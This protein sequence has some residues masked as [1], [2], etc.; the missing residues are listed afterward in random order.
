M[1]SILI[2]IHNGIEFIDDSVTSV[3]NQSCSY[4][5]ILIGVNGHPENSEI[6]KIAKKYEKKH[7]KIRVF[8]FY[9]LRGKVNTLNELIQYC[10]YDH[11]AVLDV[12]DVWH[13]Y[14]LDIQL[15]YIKDYDIVGSSCIYFGDINGTMPNIPLGDITNFDFRIINPMINSSVIIKKELCK[16]YNEGLE[17]YEMWLRYWKQGKKFFNCGE[18]L[19][20]HRIHSNSAYNSK[21][22]DVLK[23]ELLEKI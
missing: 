16:W 2:P 11:I 5:E 13:P 8:D 14:K 20:L 10:N 23:N 7:K 22:N 1:I 15:R 4:W 6:Y 9:F 12:D 21:G 18:N 19:I 17:D 3:I